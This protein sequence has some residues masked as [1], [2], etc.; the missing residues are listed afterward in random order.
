MFSRRY[1]GPMKM[2][3]ALSCALLLAGCATSYDGRGLTPGGSSLDDVI[4][5]MGAPAMRFAEP[6]GGQLLA[7]P[8]GPAG[9]H[10][11][12]LRTDPSGLLMSR[13][14]VLEPKHFARLRQ[15]MTEDE[16]LR[17]IGPPW[18]SWTVYFAARDELVWEWRWCDDWGEPARFYVLFDGTSRKL[19]STA[20]LTERLNSNAG[21]DNGREWCSR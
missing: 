10:T 17:V 6:D 3:L 1:Q 20:S 5:V 18:P 14:N 11:Y 9:Y 21:W 16:V 12:M 4:Q 19:R 2:I 7:Y 15:G 8:R 13:E